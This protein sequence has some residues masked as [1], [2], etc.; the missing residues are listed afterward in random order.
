MSASLLTVDGVELIAT[1]SAGSAY[2]YV[3]GEPS[4]ELTAAGA[5]TLMLLQTP[6]AATLQIGTRWAVAPVTLDRIRIRIAHD[7]GIAA[8]RVQLAWA[9]LTVERVTV[10][11]REP[12]GAGTELASSGSAQYPPFAAIFSIAL[13]R[14]RAALVVSALTGTRGILSATYHATVRASAFTAPLT[15]TTDVAAWFAD[16]KPTIISV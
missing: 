12:S 14:D 11:L 9:A 6:A 4:P 16:R 5:P 7:R 2:A 8:D 1:D 10:D 13:T 3:P 15:R